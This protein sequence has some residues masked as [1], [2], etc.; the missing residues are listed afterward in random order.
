VRP[1]DPAS[2]RKFAAKST[3][4]RAISLHRAAFTSGNLCFNLIA[5]SPLRTVV[6]MFRR[7]AAELKVRVDTDTEP[8]MEERR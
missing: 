6:G 4:S 5:H 2:R 1:A 3:F 8:G 7:R